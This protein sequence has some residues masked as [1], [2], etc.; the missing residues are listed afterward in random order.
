MSS[1]RE[2]IAAF[3]QLAKEEL[4]VASWLVER[5]PRQCAYLVQQAAE[6]LESKAAI[7]PSEFKKHA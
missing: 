4:D 2:R 1:Q 5:A 3:L 6:K 7:Y